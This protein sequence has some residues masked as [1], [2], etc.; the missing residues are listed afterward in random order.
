MRPL[1]GMNSHVP[2]KFTGMFKSSGTNITFVRSFFGMYASVDTKVFFYTEAF[3][4]EFAP[5]I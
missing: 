5:G 2:M 3:V 4:A 1:A